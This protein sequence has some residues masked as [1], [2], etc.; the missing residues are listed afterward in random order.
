[1]SKKRERRDKRSE[2]VGI[3][4]GKLGGG[5]GTGGEGRDGGGPTERR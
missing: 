2:Q 3:T 5:I 4:G 1:M